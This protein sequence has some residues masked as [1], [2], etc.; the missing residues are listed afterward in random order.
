MKIICFSDIHLEIPKDLTLPKESDADLLILAGDVLNM[1][2]PLPLVPFLAGWDKPAIFVPGNHEYYTSRPMREDNASFRAWL[3]EHYPQVR[4]LLDESCEIGGVQFFGGTMWTDFA[5]RNATAMAE[6]ANRMRDYDLI[7][8]DAGA[9]LQ[10]ADTITLH[11]TFKK[12]LLIWLKQP[13]KGPRVIV[14]HHAPALHPRS[15]HDGSPLIP[16]FNSLDMLEIIEKYQPRLWFYGHTHEC[17]RQIIGKTQV[18]SNQLG[19]RTRSGDYECAQDFDATGAA[20][21]I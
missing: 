9:V 17:D 7:R 13:L 4:L 3:A 16:A 10:P 5:N 8:T 6:A 12:K 20:T 14:T 11:E 2:D 21:E 1:D 18:I 19:Y 15:R